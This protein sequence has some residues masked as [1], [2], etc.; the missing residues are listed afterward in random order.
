MAIKQKRNA[1]GGGKGSVDFKSH[2]EAVRAN[3]MLTE[4]AQHVAYE[5]IVPSTLLPSSSVSRSPIIFKIKQQ[6]G[7]MLRM[8]DLQLALTFKV[9]EVTSNGHR[10]IPANKNVA[11]IDY[12]LNTLFEDV[13]VH[14]NGEV[15]YTSNI[16]YGKMSFV[17]QLL[18][19]KP[20]DRRT[21]LKSAG[22]YNALAGSH[23]NVS[24]SKTEVGETTER[25]DLI[26]DSKDVRCRGYLNIDIFNTDNLFPDNTDITI[27]ML[28]NR[29]EILL[30][31]FVGAVAQNADATAP[32]FIGYDVIISEAQLIVPRVSVI[33]KIPR[34]LRYEYTQ[35]KIAHYVCN[36]GV[37]EHTVR[38]TETVLPTLVACFFGTEQQHKGSYTT[39]FLELP[40]C[41]VK[42]IMMKCNNAVRGYDQLDL[43]QKRSYLSAFHG[44]YD[45]LA[46]T[47]DITIE[48]Y[49]GGMTVFGFDPTPTQT[50]TLFS[51]KKVH[52]V[53]DLTVTYGTAPTTNIVIYTLMIYPSAFTFDNHGHLK[54][55][56]S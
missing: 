14:A 46:S 11:I 28:M 47:G 33:G 39:D 41:N 16:L 34:S 42:S 25:K 30:T 13:I 15:I 44:L 2:D 24:S 21:Y 29:S 4:N 38:L 3:A 31:H 51:T 50:G 1:G 20:E 10:K 17:K 56:E 55:L 49:K 35:Y 54:F 40:D 6:E 43:Q 23:G 18:W 12:C 32:T 48:Q 53:L 27:T 19:S 8:N 52:G 36:A 45:V 9:Q 7:Q 22:W 37:S 5:S 26:E